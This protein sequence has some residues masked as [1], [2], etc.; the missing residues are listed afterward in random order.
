MVHSYCWIKIS[1]PS[2]TNLVSLHQKRL[3]FKK[4][5]IV[6]LKKEMN[7]FIW[8]K[9]IIFAIFFY[10]S[11]YEVENNLKVE[12]KLFFQRHYKG[13]GASKWNAPPPQFSKPG[14][15]PNSLTSCRFCSS[16]THHL[17]ELCFYNIIFFYR[18]V[19]PLHQFMPLYYYYL[20]IDLQKCTSRK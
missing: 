11:I 7:I 16:I 1:H 3:F 4:F 18:T 15:S 12:N 19:S 8:L 17:S 14:Y 13:Q 5:A 9:N 2:L 6:A 10:T 20:P